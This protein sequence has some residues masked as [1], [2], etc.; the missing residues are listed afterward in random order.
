MLQYWHCLANIPISN[1]WTR[2]YKDRLRGPLFNI[3]PVCLPN[4][5]S[6]RHM[7]GNLWG[8]PPHSNT[9]SSSSS[10]EHF[11]YCIVRNFRGIKLPQ[12]SRFVAIHESFLRKNLILCTSEQS[13]KVFYT[14]ICI[15]LPCC[16]VVVLVLGKRTSQVLWFLRTWKHHKN[17]SSCLHYA[18][19]CV[20]LMWR[21]LIWFQLFRPQGSSNEQD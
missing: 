13:A 1:S 8:L 12:I 21:C 18:I 2:C 11:N 16:C 6:H 19:T 7:W 10:P 5:T 4:I 15:S 14:K 17:N 3:A 9:D 20:W